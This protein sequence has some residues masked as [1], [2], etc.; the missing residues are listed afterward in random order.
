M[1]PRLLKSDLQCG[2]QEQAVSSARLREWERQAGRRS[3]GQCG[4]ARGTHNQ[5]R[6]VRA[7]MLRGMLPNSALL[8]KLLCKH[9]T[10]ASGVPRCAKPK[11]PRAPAGTHSLVRPERLP[12]ELGRV[13]ARPFWIS[14]LMCGR[15]QRGRG[16]EATPRA[17]PANPYLAP[18]PRSQASSAGFSHRV[19][20]PC[21]VAGHA[22]EGAGGAHVW[23]A[24]SSQQPPAVILR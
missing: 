12:N 18:L 19:H 3:A 24:A 13:P 2:T 22:R 6:F 11:V 23:C 1:M 7:Q 14:E 16:T 8:L 21:A 9:R 5:F 10:R 17:V 15:S 20:A 4:A